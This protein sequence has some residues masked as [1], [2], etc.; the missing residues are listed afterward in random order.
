MSYA[1]MFLCIH[2]LK[3]IF[4]WSFFICHWTNI[5]PPLPQQV[6][7]VFADLI[8]KLARV[9]KQQAWLQTK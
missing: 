5:P 1:V 6:H 8:L 2:W 9:L 4:H 7:R 3:S